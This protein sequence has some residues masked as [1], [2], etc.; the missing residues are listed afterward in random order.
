MLSQIQRATSAGGGSG[1]RALELSL[2]RISGKANE[3]QKSLDASTARVIAFGAT[4]G[5]LNNLSG[6][7]KRMVESSIEVQN[8]LA[9]INVLLNLSSKDL[10]KFSSDLFKVANSTSQ[11]FSDATKAAQEFARQG[12]GME[13][14]LQRTKDALTLTRLSGI[15]LEDSISSLTAATNSFSREALSVLIFEYLTMINLQ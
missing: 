14:T 2:G 8:S 6:A 15:S 13:Q 7:F 1:S 5:I 12:L 9:D 10:S 4:A 11:S 3:F